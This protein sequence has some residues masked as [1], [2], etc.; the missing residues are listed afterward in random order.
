MQD[1]GELDCDAIAQSFEGTYTYVHNT[2]HDITYV[3][4][5][6]SFSMFSECTHSRPPLSPACVSD[7]RFNMRMSLCVL[8]MQSAVVFRLGSACVSV[9]LH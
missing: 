8:L 9:F 6:S 2:S 3:R 7:Y 5:W 4:A 1:G